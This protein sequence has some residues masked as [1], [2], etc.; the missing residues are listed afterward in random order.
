MMRNTN[1]TIYWLLSRVKDFPSVM[2]MFDRIDLLENLWEWS[3]G[4]EEAGEMAAV[5][6]EAEEFMCKICPKVQYLSESV[7][8]SFCPLSRAVS[9][10][11]LDCSWATLLHAIRLLKGGLT[12]AGMTTN[13][14][15][16]LI[17]AYVLVHSQSY[18]SPR[19]PNHTETFC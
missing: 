16:K 9:T 11:Q 4:E 2:V 12:F 8:E 19:K 13:V 17:H 6:P 10:K 5:R 14:Q 18:I 15:I 7:S 3:F 1:R